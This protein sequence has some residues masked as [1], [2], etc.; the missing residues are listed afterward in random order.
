MAGEDAEKIANTLLAP[1]KHLKSSRGTAADAP[2][3]NASLSSSSSRPALPAHDPEKAGP[4]KKSTPVTWRNLPNKKQLAILAGVRVVDFFQVASL[5]T[6]MFH[7]LKSFS[8]SL[9]DSKI[10]LQAGVMQGV[11]TSAQI[12]TAIL[13]GNIADA[14]WA[15]RKNVLLI[16]LIGTALSCIGVGYSTT[17][18]QAVVFRCLGGAINGTVGAARTMVAESVDKKYHSRAFLLLPIAFNIANVIGPI[19]GGLMA[20][21]AANYPNTLGPNTPLGGKKYMKWLHTFPYAAPNLLSAILLLLEAWIVWIGLQ[22]T[23][24]SRRYVRD[25]GRELGENISYW[26][27][28]LRFHS[29]YSRVGQQLGSEDHELDMSPPTTP[30]HPEISS[31]K[32]MSMRST[33]RKRLAFRKIWTKNVIMVLITT[34]I[35]DFQ[36]GGFANLWLLFLSA[37]RADPAAKALDAFHFSGGMSF[38]PSLIGRSMAILGIFGVVL[39]FSL[40]PTL[41][42]R[43]GLLRSFQLSLLLFPLAYFLAPYLALLPSSSPAPLPASGFLIWAGI[44]V[45]LFLQVAAR[46]FAL[47]ATIILLNNASPHPSVL[48]TIHGLG[49]SASSTFRT[50]GPIAAGRWFGTGLQR[51]MVGLA[52]WGLSAVS[53]LGVLGGF[54]VENGNGHSIKLEGEVEEEQRGE[55]REA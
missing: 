48:G 21:P 49:S 42:S 25:R 38:P 22:E 7:Q 47:P 13:W 15:G 41:S 10:S 31:A 39:Q 53:I 54:F 44:A 3:Y 12:V 14:P 24:E 16:G 9:P 23:L 8:P 6:Y 29:G 33:P 34:A 35:F 11:F 2:S 26:L 51:D 40:Y 46:T 32:E 19:F 43:W 1:P 52:W 36:M 18:E 45:V 37:A 20:D 30:A 5:Q 50:I 17:F 28:K 4:E 27:G 55:K